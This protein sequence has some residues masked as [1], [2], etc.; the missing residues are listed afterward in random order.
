MQIEYKPA[1]GRGFDIHAEGGIIGRLRPLVDGKG[2]FVQFTEDACTEL[3]TACFGPEKPLDGDLMGYERVPAE[4]A[5]E[6]AKEFVRDNARAA[7]EEARNYDREMAQMEA[8][9]EKTA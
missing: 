1:G 5:L 6:T 2:W 8:E 4:R 9:S 3:V 7:L